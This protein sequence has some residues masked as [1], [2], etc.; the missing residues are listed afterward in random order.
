MR[1]VAIIPGDGVGKEV[2][3]EAVRVLDALWDFEPVEARMGLECNR[4]TGTYLP[5]E[6]LDAFGECGLALFG[7]ITSPPDDPNYSSPLLYLRKRFELYANLRPAV[8]LHPSLGHRPID[9]VMVRENT[10]GMYGAKEVTKGHPV[11]R[12]VTHRT[13][14]RKASVRI[15]DFALR[16]ALDNGRSRVSCLHKANVLRESDALFRTVFYGR[17]RRFPRICADDYHVDAAALHLIR[18][19][20]RFDVLVTL[21]L[22]GDIISDEMAGLVGGLGFMPSGNIGEN[23]ALFEPV[24]GAA[25]DIAGKGVA[26]PCAA[27][28]SAAMLLR[29]AGEPARADK[30]AEAVKAVLA[31]GVFTKDVGGEY[32]TTAFTDEVLKALD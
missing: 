12:V 5:Q 18:E 27:I 22:Y 19:P 17:A 30:L 23:A 31:K 11:Q 24:H 10:E 13:V 2:V 6:T 32:G 26:N 9:I 21:N 28:L 29:H 4:D 7:S 3:P 14:T 15:C 8:L 25:P 1:K 20:E 16:Y